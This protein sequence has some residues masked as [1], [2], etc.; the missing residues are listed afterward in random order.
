MPGK[1]TSRESLRFLNEVAA[2]AKAGVPMPEGLRAVAGRGEGGVAALA[3]AAAAETERGVP[4]S[5]ALRAASPP[6]PEHIAALVECG[7]Q[8]GD[9]YGVLDTARR[10]AAVADRLRETFAT[11]VT[12]PALVI[13]VLLVVTQFISFVVLPPFFDIYRQLGAELPWLTQQV[14]AAMK[15]AGSV[16]GIAVSLAAAVFVLLLITSHNVR[17]TVSEAVASRVGYG[18]TMRLGEAMIVSRCLA[19]LLKHGAVLPTA[20]RAVEA[21][22]PRRSTRIMLFE[23]AKDAERGVP[24]APT[25]E[26]ALPTTA[27]YLYR[28]GEERGDLAGACESI[29]DYCEE[30]YEIRRERAA[31]MFEPVL[32]LLIGGVIA[33]ILVSLYLPLFRIPGLVR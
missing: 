27:A 21:L 26:R 22:L 12:Y 24:T 8:T 6:A 2:L 16:P 29:A 28:V 18:E 7:E 23:M 15:L 25:F 32:L 20:L 33:V 30:H 5:Q 9:L 11:A 3:S 4:L 10:Q 19:R 17:N 14:G 13:L 31:G 1:L